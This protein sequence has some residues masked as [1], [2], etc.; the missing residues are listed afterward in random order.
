MAANDPSAGLLRGYPRL[1][2]IVQ[3][4]NEFLGQ[5]HPLIF[6]T[7]ATHPILQAKRSKVIHDNLWGTVRFTWRELALIDSPIIQRLRDIHQTGLAFHVYP[8]A[9]HTRFE[10]S[11]G[12]VTIASRIFDA[13]VHRQRDEI[14]DVVKALWRNLDPDVSILRLKQELRLA[15]LLHDTGHS[16]YSHTSELVYETLEPLAEASQEL[17]QFVGKQKGAGEV[18]SFCC[19]LTPAISQLLERT[20]NKGLI[21]D[22]ASD[23]YDGPIDLTN[24]ALIIVGRSSHPFLQF[25]GD[26]VSSAF[27]ADKLDYLLR[28]AQNAG[29]PLRYDLDRYLYDVRIDREVLT[30]GEG[31]LD[32]LYTQTKAT[33]KERKPPTSETRYPYFDTYRLRLS[34]RAMNVIEQIIICKMMLF[35]YIYHHPKV[36]ASDGLLERLLRRRVAKWRLN[37]ESD[38]TVL[39]RFLRMTDAA[40]QSGDDGDDDIA[41]EYQY[42]LM[43]RLL[44]REV[45]SI[46]GPSA[47]HAEG[48]LIQ[49]FLTELH[50]RR[51]RKTLIDDLERLIGDELIKMDSA[52]G[53]T[54]SEAAARAGIWVDAPKPPKF[55][56]V[57]EMIMGARSTSA[58]VP[59]AQLFPI[60]EWTQAYE[61][62]RYQVR[63]FAFSRYFAI[64][65]A[66][67]KAA[68]KQRLR[69][70]S[71]SFY[72]R[73]RRTRR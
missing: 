62:Y 54:P 73:I 72:D 18:L 38:R 44:P 66:A 14:R 33:A 1:A 45:Y 20:E 7:A 13:V 25:L 64:A 10:H 43:N 51:L 56:D 49:D 69:I 12:A 34:R 9:R 41:N 59:L 6:G 21:G 42:R 23:D 16:L 31:E 52:L 61:H 50:D 40:L 68:M 8:S 57:D 28:D 47:T 19:T 36:R 71:D 11:L 17:S 48:V 4:L 60:R 5:S 55:E 24:V 35:S 39:G 29:L 58:G 46:S 37:G 65:A 27:D 26:I 70:S 32:K 2:E 30:D 53:P 15:A 3:Q 67:A 22:R 63:I